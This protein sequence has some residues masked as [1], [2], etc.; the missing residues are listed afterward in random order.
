MHKVIRPWLQ[1]LKQ[2]VTGCVSGGGIHQRVS[3]NL[4]AGRSIHVA[5]QLDGH[6]ADPGFTR[7]MNTIIKVSAQ[8]SCT[9]ALIDPDTVAKAHWRNKAKVN[10][11]IAGVIN[12]AKT[13]IMRWAIACGWIKTRRNTAVTAEIAFA[14]RLTGNGSQINHPAE[15]TCVFREGSIDAIII[16]INICCRSKT[17]DTSRLGTGR[18]AAVPAR[19]RLTGGKVAGCDFNK[20]MTGVQ[21]IE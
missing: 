1:T 16:V 8:R 11:H 2:I 21:V 4:Q 19:Q 17:I 14:R 10:G 15:N 3:R 18:L 13:T 5:P 20:V 9:R 6:A 12:L 7:I